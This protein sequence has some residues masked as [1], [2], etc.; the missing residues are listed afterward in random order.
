[1]SCSLGLTRTLQFLGK[2]RV[3]SHIFFSDHH[4]ENKRLRLKPSTCYMCCLIETAIEDPATA[5]TTPTQSLASK[6]TVQVIFIVS[7]FLST[8]H[9]LELNLNR[10]I[11]IQK[12]LSGF[13][14]FIGNWKGKVSKFIVGPPPPLPPFKCTFVLCL[15]EPNSL[16]FF[17]SLSR[18]NN[19]EIL[20]SEN[21]VVY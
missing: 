11:T 20:L 19:G 8:I 2:Q 1:M 6:L 21:S 13:V 5:A 4:W 16:S 14:S 17:L 18:R 7:F 15:L 3:N 12:F 10:P 9:E